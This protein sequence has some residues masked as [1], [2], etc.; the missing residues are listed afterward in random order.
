M[1][2]ALFAA[3]CLSASMAWAGGH[4]DGY[5]QPSAFGSGSHLRF[6]AV[7]EPR[8]DGLVG[9]IYYFN[10]QDKGTSGGTDRHFS[11]DID[12]QLIHFNI[13]TTPNVDCVG[14]CP[15]VAEVIDA[16]LDMVVTPFMLEQD[17]SSV[18]V[19]EVRRWQGG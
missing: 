5:T 17:E 3:A 16:P 11:V 12:G 9:L 15:D 19:F 18:G 6:E 8:T 4:D 2:S 10:G 14:G 1:R 7:D 13:R